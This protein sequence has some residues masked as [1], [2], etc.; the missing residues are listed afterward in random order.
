MNIKKQL[1]KIFV[2]INKENNVFKYFKNEADSQLV[3]KLY[4][5]L[6][7]QVHT[8]RLNHDN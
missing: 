8:V 1:T 7:A 6:C 4:Y 5:A 3:V 2:Q